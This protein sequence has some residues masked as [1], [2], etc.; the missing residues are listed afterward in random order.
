MASALNMHQPDDPEAAKIWNC[1]NCRRRKVRCDRVDPCSNCSKLGLDCHYPVSGRVA[2]RN[3]APPAWESPH[4]KQT[5]LL[6]R[7]QRLEA[8][9]TELA[10]QMSP[11]EHDGDDDGEAEFG[12]LLASQQGKISI[13]NGFWSVFCDEIDEIFGA[14]QA[15]NQTTQTTMQTPARE[16]QFPFQFHRMSISNLDDVLNDNISFLWQQFLEKVDPFIKV[17]HTPTTNHLFTP[18]TSRD[19]YE[20]ALVYAVALST[21][22]A[23]D[24]EDILNRFG[25]TKADVV[26]SIGA[27]LETQ[28]T[29]VGFLTTNNITTI[30]AFA[31]FV[32]TLPYIGESKTTSQMTG[33]LLQL[34]T[35]TCTDIPDCAQDDADTRV[36]GEIRRRIWW[37]TCFLAR[38]SLQKMLEKFF[39]ANLPVVDFPTN[40]SDE[41][42]S[43]GRYDGE[44][45]PQMTIC[46]I[47]CQ[48][49]TLATSIRQRQDHDLADILQSIQRCKDVIS[50]KYLHGPPEQLSFLESFA[51][52][53]TTLFFN[54]LEQSVYIRYLQSI[55]SD[56]SKRNEL[57]SVSRAIFGTSLR[58]LEACH[59]MMVESW[60][61]DWSWQLRGQ[62]PWHAMRIVFLCLLHQPWTKLSEASWV[63]AHKV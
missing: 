11:E 47:R 1:I 28:L 32:F 51:S 6:E 17:L 40:I 29:N 18:I 49:W 5:A 24:D 57:G 21:V 26:H 41:E 25:H 48:L 34:V 43:L 61:Q 56:S 42:L 14:I 54:K 3:R 31:I 22:A 39:T 35:G 46:L 10:V 62:F 12:Q 58:A 38:R 53:M 2:R 15:D 45:S 59:D 44:S 33:I 23:L 55:A 60:A 50:T 19:A 63:L 27:A 20:T 8:I 36:D 30:Q 16:T 13:G 4:Q 52:S 37:H 7:V 9:V